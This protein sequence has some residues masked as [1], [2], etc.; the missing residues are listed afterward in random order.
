MISDVASLRSEIAALQ[1]ELHRDFLRLETK[2][3]RMPGIGALYLAT[4]TLM[5][6]IGAVVTATVV[7]LKN[8]GLI[9]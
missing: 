4:V 2:V 9:D 5:L 3:D 6:G 8:V 1:H 7:G